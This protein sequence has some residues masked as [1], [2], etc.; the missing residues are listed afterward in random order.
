MKLKT[1]YL[2][3][4]FIRFRFYTMSFVYFLADY[5]NSIPDL[6]QFKMPSPFDSINLHG[7]LAVRKSS[8]VEQSVFSFTS[9]ILLLLIVF[10][11]R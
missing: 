4:E 2:R 8:S 9:S 5:I 11:C 1:E 7:H 3:A 10:S 6:F